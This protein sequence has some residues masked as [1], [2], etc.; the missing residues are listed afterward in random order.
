[1]GMEQATELTDQFPRCDYE[2]RLVEET[3]PAA[4]WQYGKEVE[5]GWPYSVVEWLGRH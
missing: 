3:L 2:W 4:Q 1:M 5:H